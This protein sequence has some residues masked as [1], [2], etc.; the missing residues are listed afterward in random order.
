[1]KMPKVDKYL[2]STDDLTSK[3][4]KFY[5]YLSSN[6]ETGIYPSLE[7]NSSYLSVY[8]GSYT[9]NAKKIGFEK[10]RSKM[11]ELAEAY[12]SE[13]E[14]RRAC[15]HS[16]DVCL[17]GLEKYDEYLANLFSDS[18]RSIL[19]RD[20]YR[21][22]LRCNIN[23]YLGRP[24]E[25]VDLIKMYSGYFTKYT[26]ENEETFKDFIL[27]ALDE[28]AEN[29]GPWLKRLFKDI[30]KPRWKTKF[31][32]FHLCWSK[33]YM[34]EFDRTSTMGDYLKKLFR[35]TENKF[36]DVNG[37]AKVR[38]SW[39]SETKLYNEIKKAF[40]KTE[41]IQH[42]RPRWLGRQHLDIWIPKWKI[43]IEYQ[44][45]QHFEPIKFFGGI[46][47]L[48]NAKERDKRKQLL[49][50]L[51]KVELI[52]VSDGESHDEVI[53]QVIEIRRLKRKNL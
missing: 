47:G 12:K 45:K 49:C 39:A 36:R 1:M 30:E 18:P 11:L 27:N 28:D 6:I 44:G 35:E 31:G 10:L 20:R 29:N 46:E 37:I 3:Q 52:L 17:L 24:A 42:G 25:T 8:I 16:A 48:K 4:L 7:G 9:N 22:N 53:N 23:Y 51:N 19:C 41:V 38:D 34:Y 15:R 40:P 21:A 50:E 13:E 5:Q 43:G 14:I 2:Y 32:L 26:R 33:F